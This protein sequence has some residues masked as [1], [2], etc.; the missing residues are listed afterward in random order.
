M[1]PSR[2]VLVLAIGAIS[3]SVTAAASAAA[4]TPPAGSWG[5]AIEVPGLGA[6]N[7]D[8]F[9]EVRSV[10]CGSAGNCVAGG[11]YRDRRGRSQGFVTVERGGH[12][13]T[14]IEVP[15][16][17]ALNAGGDAEVLSVSCGAAGNCAIGGYYTVRPENSQGFVAVERDG[18]WGTAI[19]VPGLAGLNKGGLAEVS[20]VSCGSAGSCAAGGNYDLASGYSVGFVAVERGGR[21]GAAIEVPGLDALVKLNAAVTSVS[22][23]AAGTCVAGGWYIGHRGGLQ[24][25]VTDERGGRW[26]T[27]IEVPGLA[28]LNKKAIAFLGSVSCGSA[29]S[30]AAGGFYVD[31]GDHQQGFVAVERGGRWTEAIEVPGLAAL[32][33]DEEASVDTVSCP[34]AGNCAIGGSYIDGHGQPRWFVAS[35][36]NGAWRKAIPVPGVPALPRG[37]GPGHEPLSCGSAGNCAV[38]GEY[39]DRRGHRQAFVAVERGRW[40]KAIEVPGLGSLNAGGLAF[41]ESVSCTPSGGCAA[42]GVYNA[43]H[44]RSQGFVVSLTA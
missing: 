37:Y 2:C 25:F 44:H 6:L 11:Y 32:N 16:L 35:Q 29:G 43:G 1:R 38:G 27:A 39:Y 12:W 24:V 7:R 13:G 30:C 23:V 22:C 9:A 5:K 18:R 19:E 26:S 10:S 34:S 28:A 4:S 42:G 31:R 33:K 20:S 40:G 3:L 15:G 41:I 8:G 17:G 21:W 14:A 36:R